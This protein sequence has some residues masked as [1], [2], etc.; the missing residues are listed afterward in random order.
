MHL[1]NGEHGYGV[2]TKLLHWLTVAAVA[3]TFLV[4]H[5]MDFDQVSAR[6]TPVP[7]VSPA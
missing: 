1:R 3:G 2:V 6:Q 4:G 7:S 5:R